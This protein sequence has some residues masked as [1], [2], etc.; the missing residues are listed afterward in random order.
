MKKLL[1]LAIAIAFGMS[2]FVAYAVPATAGE[3]TMAQGASCATPSFSGP[4]YGSGY[5]G[6]MVLDPQGN[7]LGRVFDLMSAAEGTVDYLIVYSCL[8]GM[9]DKLVAIPVWDFDT[10]QRLG[11]V[12]V[13]VTKQQFLGAPAISSQEWS[14]LGS[15]WTY[16]LE[17]NHHYFEGT[18]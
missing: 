10:P 11:T 18:Y 8:P 12:T 2:M 15:R 4:S 9:S 14:D 13:S 6:A 1:V 16:W 17:D 5:M 3:D 7:G